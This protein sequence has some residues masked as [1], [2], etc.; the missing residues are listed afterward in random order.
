MQSKKN[1]RINTNSRGLPTRSTYTERTHAEMLVTDKTFLDC[2]AAVNIKPT[3]RQMS[4]WRR[5]FGLARSV[6]N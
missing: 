6:L 3:K 4:K 1:Y 2:C 5:G